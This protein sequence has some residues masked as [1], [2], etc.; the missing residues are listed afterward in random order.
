MATDSPSGEAADATPLRY[1]PLPPRR[2]PPLP[3]PR[4]IR[5]DPASAPVAPPPAAPQVSPLGLPDRVTVPAAEPSVAA[6]PAGN[7]PLIDDCDDLRSSRRLVRGLL[8]CF[9]SMCVNLALLLILALFAL[10]ILDVRTHVSEITVLPEPVHDADELHSVTV[11]DDALANDV[12]AVAEVSG[13]Q[14]G[15]AVEPLAEVKQHPEFSESLTDSWTPDGLGPFAH[16]PSR[17]VMDQTVTTGPPLSLPTERTLQ[18]AGTVEEAVDG[19]GGQIRDRLGDGDTLVVWLLDASIS[20]VDDR[21]RI[22]AHL[23]DVYSEIDREQ[24]ATYD[25][26]GREAPQL[27]NAVVAFGGGITEVLKPTKQIDLVADAIAR[28]PVDP[29]GLEYVMEAT[30]RTVTKYRAQRAKFGQV[31][32]VIWTD[33]SGDDITLLEPT[34]ALCRHERVH[35]SVIAPTATLGAQDGLHAYFHPVARRTF[36]L[37]V[38]KGPDTA[39]P[40]RLLWP[41]WSHGQNVRQVEGIALDMAESLAGWQGGP[42][43]RCLASGFAPYALTRLALETGGTATIFDREADRGPFTL[44]VMRPYA[45]DYRAAED[46]YRELPKR[47]LRQLVLQSIEITRSF[48][49]PQVVYP[50]AESYRPA[51]ALRRRVAERNENLRA[52]ASAIELALAPFRRD[53]LERLREQEESPRWRAWFDLTYGRL[54][55]QSVRY[56][57]FHAMTLLATARVPDNPGGIPDSA[58]CLTAAPASNLWGGA[59]H[60]ARAREAERLLR[61]CIDEHPRTPFAL[62]AA[63]ELAT[64]L[65]FAFQTTYRPPPPPPPP[66]PASPP[67]AP[68]QAPPP[69]VFPKL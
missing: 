50:F 9:A 26:Y 12:E 17:H 13:V 56:A 11:A 27:L 60:E 47:P 10:P 20:L 25:R 48:S 49:K 64:P 63:Q 42:H 69:L 36:Y 31:L 68:V 54:L 41:Y 4:A 39:F 66:R 55:A 45:P 38:L 51:D 65:G 21:Q 24:R 23:Q 6:P 40:E 32:L 61:R 15:V 7:L 2:P 30:A 46:I 37:P 5:A 14:V 52:S 3:P 33:E 43:L 1:R 29:S 34:I 62:L 59:A 57:E 18:R 8:P 44:D 22:A 19:L 28:L 16:L 67:S 58:N 53:G 35:V